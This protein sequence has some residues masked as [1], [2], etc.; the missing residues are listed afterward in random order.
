V[1]VITET[2]WANLFCY[3]SYDLKQLNLPILHQ[4][5]VLCVPSFM[6]DPAID[7]TRNF[8]ILDFT[9]VVLIGGT[10]YTGEMKK[11]IFSALNFILPV[12]K[13][14]TYAL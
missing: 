13:N 9:K 1:R 7:G 11:G 4:R 12:F 6:A 14:I 8:A 5:M 2:P 3:N 10:G